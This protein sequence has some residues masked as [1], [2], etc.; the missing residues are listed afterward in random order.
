M[1]DAAYGVPRKQT[2]KA[3]N[4][5][6]SLEAVRHGQGV[7]RWLERGP[8]EATRGRIFPLWRFQVWRWT[9]FISV[10]LHSTAFDHKRLCLLHLLTPWKEF[11]CSQMCAQRSG[12]PML[13]LEIVNALNVAI[14]PVVLTCCCFGT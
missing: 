13:P 14:T 9:R 12:L 4:L 7:V 10:Q 2:T 11:A 1:G 3:A 6:C 8:T 5:H